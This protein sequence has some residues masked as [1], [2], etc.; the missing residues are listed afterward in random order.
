[1][2]SSFYHLCTETT[3]EWCEWQSGLC[4]RCVVLDCNCVSYWQWRQP[5]SVSSCWQRSPLDGG[6]TVTAVVPQDDLSRVCSSHQQV[7]MKPGETHRYYRR[8]GKQTEREEERMRQQKHHAYHSGVR[9]FCGKS[10]IKERISW[11]DGAT[12]WQLECFSPMRCGDKTADSEKR[13]QTMKDM[14]RKR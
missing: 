10:Y 3:V 7:G 14:K 5:Y 11:I 12:W 6:P 4:S 2:I 1:M 13:A 9:L 8:L